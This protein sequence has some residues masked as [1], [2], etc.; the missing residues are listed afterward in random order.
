MKSILNGARTATIVGEVRTP[1]PADERKIFVLRPMLQ[2]GRRDGR[3][4]NSVNVVWYAYGS[5]RHWKLLMRA[6]SE[7]KWKAVRIKTLD[8][9]QISGHE[10]YWLRARFKVSKDSA[11][12][13]Y[14]LLFDEAEVFT[15]TGKVPDAQKETLR[16]VVFGDFADGG[17]G[18][19]KIGRAAL[20]LSPDLVIMPGD[21]VYKSGLFSEYRKY[22][23]P[24]LSETGSDGSALASSVT[25]VAAVGNHDVRIPDHED[26]QQ[27]SSKFD[28]FAYFR[29]WHQP[30][31]GPIL[32]DQLVK[33]MV[34][35]RAE[36]QALYEQFGADFVRRSNFYFS[37]GSA[38]WVV[39]DAN[40]YMDWRLD[41]LQKWLREALEAGK[42][43]SWRFVTFHQPGF[44][45][46]FKYRGDWRM[47]VLAPIFEEFSV[48]V[49]FSGHCHFYERHR[50]L[51]FLPNSDESGKKRH[52]SGVLTV[53]LDFEGDLVRRPRGV[54]YIV[55]GAGG[56]LLKP[57]KRPGALGASQTTAKLCDDKNS[58]TVLDFNQRTLIIRQLDHMQEEID[59]IVIE[60]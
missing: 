45:S 26:E 52:P 34:A 49:V 36:G 59:H 35:K 1:A 22:L 3:S 31:N 4:G 16:T 30:G 32:K 21:I 10:I 40:K 17:T 46:D 19:S 60:K 51:K 13:E 11:T 43:K 58:L 9:L 42:D 54:I 25:M 24:I 48:D 12:F 56:T 41:D 18:A 20:S 14:K 15:S 47:R 28:L 57:E 39:L 27:H 53:D 29:T 2:L 44:N 33:T 50:P 7:A 38:H 55:T 23:E 8:S 37:Q 6:S 5:K